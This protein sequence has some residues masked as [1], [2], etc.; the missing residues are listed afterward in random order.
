MPDP[1]DAREPISPVLERETLGALPIRPYDV[2]LLPIIPWE[3]RFQ[4]PQQIATQFGR[5]GHRVFQLSLTRF[6]SAEGPAGELHTLAENVFEVSAPPLAGPGIYAAEP[7]EEDL[8]RLEEVFG[9]LAQ[10]QGI[11]RA[12]CLVDLPSWAPLA[13]R[14]RER[15]GWPI[16]YDCLDDWSAFPG[17]GAAV[18]SG[19]GSLVRAADLTIVVSK[20]LLG[21]W[22]EAAARL[23]LVPSGVDLSHYLARFGPTEVLRDVR[24]PVI[25]YF[26]AIASW[27]DVPLLEKIARRFP[28]ATLVLAGERFDVDLAALEALPNVRLLGDRPYDEMPALLWHFDVCL[29]P[30]LVNELTEASNLVKL[31]EYCYGGQPVVAT[32]LADLWPHAGFVSLARGHEEF[33]AHV[34]DALQEPPDDPRRLARRRLAASSGWETRFRTIDEAIRRLEEKTWSVVRAGHLAEVFERQVRRAREALRRSLWEE[35]RA[36]EDRALTAAREEVPR[37]ERTLKQVERA[38]EDSQDRLHVTSRELLRIQQSRLWSAA[39]VYWS[40]RRRLR[41][42]RFLFETV[43]SAVAPAEA[44]RAEVIPPASPNRYDVL[45]FPIIDWDFRFQ[46]PQQL[47][48]RF[49]EAGHRVFYIATKMR[50][51]GPSYQLRRVAENVYEVSLRGAQKNIYQDPM[52]EGE[53]RQAAEALDRMRRELSLGATALFVQLPFWW[54]L[55]RSL[56][57]R[58]QWPVVYDCMDHHAGFSYNR[59]D[60]LA[61][62]TELLDSA[63]LVLSSSSELEQQARRHNRRVLLLR[64]A[65]DYEH[66]AR[67]EPPQAS[68]A[69]PVIGYYG[70]IAEWFDSDLVADLAEK[71]PDWR[72]LLVGSTWAGDTARLARLSNVELAGEKPYAEIPSWLA[73]FDVVL[74]PFKRMPLTEATNPVKSYEILAG[75]RPL[76]SVPLPEIA[77]MAPL[78]RMA[79]TPAEFEK[80]IEAA[81][82]DRDPERTEAGRAFARENTWARRFEELAPATARAFPLVSIVVVTYNNLDMNRQCLE[83]LFGQTGWPNLEVFV[84][85]NAS[86]D[87]TREYLLESERLYPNLRVMINESNLG[88]AAANNLALERARGDFL[89]LLNNDTVVARGWLSTLLRHLSARPDIGM[90]GPVTNAIG[91]EARVEVGYDRIEEMPAWA[92]AYTRAHEDELFEIPML[93]MFC[94]AMRRQ[95]FERVGPLD[96]RFGVGMFEDDDYAIRMRKAGYG[97]LCARDSFVHHWMKASFR[98][99]PEGEYRELFEKNRRLFEEKWATPWVPHRGAGAPDSPPPARPAGPP[100]LEQREEVPEV[101]EAPVPAQAASESPEERRNGDGP[102][103]GMASLSGRCNICGND[104]AFYFKDPALYRE[105]LTCSECLATSRYRSLARGILKAVKL[106][107]GIEARSL[108]ELAREK[109]SVRLAVYDTQV[110]FRYEKDAYP[111]PD[112]L[113]R[114][115]WIDLSISRYLPKSRLGKKL[116]PKTTNQNLEKLT[117]PGESFDIVITSDVLEHVRLDEAAH[118]EIRRV[119]KPGGAH[120]FTV[121]HIRSGDTLVRIRVTDPEDPS[122]DEYLMEKEYHGDANAE[123]GRAISYRAY[124][125]DLDARLTQMGFEVEYTRQDF[126]DMGILDTELFFCLARD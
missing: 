14:L 65:C 97:I 75:G 109:P 23:L 124:G 38:L 88:F 7:A 112:L 76:V 35:F 3:F 59:P 113:S 60:M 32:D 9:S 56:R 50:P 102:F 126:P 69:P 47:M 2:I 120:V 122:R 73:K 123:D 27:I 39:S 30:F 49:G 1:L 34:G 78:V 66:F 28:Q 105:S 72:F 29:I 110:P 52:N 15:F 92:T 79:S 80:E 10:A 21:K 86:T 22:K 67:I 11:S 58:L 46:R 83:S 25:G 16:V 31:Y 81:L 104:A 111:I 107:T 85:D 13:L 89:V 90:I 19:E 6:S 43:R 117:F 17:M 8:D 64:N 87:G 96:E 84:V 53:V 100:A 68:A 63:D 33:L 98:K 125:K 93:A 114:C 36:K 12:V 103:S 119:L 99:M 116:G 82:S 24:R 42:V 94:V 41:R 106:R 4:R 45:C 101:P 62:E 55:A 108:A 70:A 44:A 37:I 20:K 26:G 71:R 121:P 5:H 40:M 51:F 18:V 48:S 115:R 95:V 74:L 54:P 77:L 118:R 57:D 91:N 61:Q